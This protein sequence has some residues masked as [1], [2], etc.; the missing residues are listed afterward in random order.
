VLIPNEYKYSLA[1]LSLIIETK[2][3]LYIGSI[4]KKNLSDK[5]TFKPKPKIME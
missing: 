1:F 3:C 5:G 2:F 4:F